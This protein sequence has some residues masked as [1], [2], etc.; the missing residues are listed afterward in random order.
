[1]AEAPFTPEDPALLAAALEAGESVQI[2]DTRPAEAFAR[3]HLP[4]SRFLPLEQLP[5]RFGEIERA[6]ER[7]VLVV[8]GDA[9]AEPERVLR[10]AGF[11]R[12]STLIDGL[13]RWTGDVERGG[14]GAQHA[15]LLD[16]PADDP[17]GAGPPARVVMD[18]YARIRAW[19]SVL[20]VACGAG[21]NAL[22]LAGEGFEVLA[23]DRD[24]QALQA[25]RARAEAGR[26]RVRWIE[27][28]L[29]ADLEAAM[30]GE[31]RGGPAPWQVAPESVDAVVICRYLWRPLMPRLAAAV[32][33]GG[34]VLAQTFTRDQPRF[35]KPTNPDFLL[36][37]GELPR[38]F[39]R[40]AILSYREGPVFGRQARAAFIARKPM[41]TVN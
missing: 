2:L 5:D 16:D 34:M 22:F 18:G 17:Y 4:H 1:M 38:F 7:L 25:A 40:W 14:P 3:A 20:D 32:R 12:V 21:G 10:A 27:A 33:P 35:G 28:D 15:P 24:A 36:N 23:V 9:P 30:D 39:P 37:P 19:G 13:A 6:T 11:A 31:A 26:L 29:Q 41:R 8:P